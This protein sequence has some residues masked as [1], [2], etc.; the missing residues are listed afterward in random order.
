MGWRRICGAYVNLSFLDVKMQCIVR[1]SLINGCF[2]RCD[3]GNDIIEPEVDKRGSTGMSW[4]ST[5]R[6]LVYT[7]VPS[8]P[9]I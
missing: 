2:R 8:F 5:C 1:E 3:L 6:G 7:R 4:F 9:D